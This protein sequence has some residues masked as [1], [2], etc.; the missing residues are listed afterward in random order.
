[1]NTASDEGFGNVIKTMPGFKSIS[2]ALLSIGGNGSPLPPEA[3]AV[4]TL[5]G[6][7][8][9][10]SGGLAGVQYTVQ[11]DRS[12]KDAAVLWPI[13]KSPLILRSVGFLGLAGNN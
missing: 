2:T 7:T 9:S 11:S 6:I 8:G 10:T 13:L 5:D 4:S 3:V 12:L 1:M